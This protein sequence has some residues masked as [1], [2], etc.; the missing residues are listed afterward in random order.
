MKIERHY[1]TKTITYLF[2]IVLGF[3]MIYP[4]I[5]LIGA[6][7]KPESEIFTSLSVFPK[8]VVWDSFQRGWEGSGQYS[9][10]VFLWNTVKLTVPTVVFTLISSALVS[11]GFARFEFPMKKFLFTL[12]LSTLMLPNAVI[13]IPRYLLFKQLDW[14]NSYLPFI[15]PAAFGC[16][17]F[18]IYLMIQF[19]RGLPKELDEAAFIDG[20]KP[21][22]V[23]LR[24]LLPLAKPGLF[25]AGLFQFIWIWNDFSNVLVYVNSIKKFP[26]SLGLRMSLDNM[27]SGNWSQVMAMSMVAIIPC[28]VLFFSAQ[29]YFVEG[30]STTGLKG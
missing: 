29:K 2:L 15:V 3:I 16:Y 26:L 20:C 1:L 7:F 6:S 11:Y 19:F 12:M 9:F 4:L 10:G 23:F 5:W 30:I 17:P 24:I 8:E 25:S 18:F 28:V 14:L 22:M 27:G 13:I 21:F